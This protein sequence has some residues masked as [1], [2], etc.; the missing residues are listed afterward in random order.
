[1]SANIFSLEGKTALVT[2]A[3][4]GLGRHFAGVL[5]RAGARVVAAAR[6]TERLE[7]LAEEIRREGGEAIPCRLDVT[8]PESVRAAFDAAEAAFGPVDV[9]IN[10]AG[11]PSNTFF[12]K[13]TEQDWRQVMD[14]NLDGV[15][16]VAQEGA[17][18]MIA[19]GKPGS[20]VNVSSVLG[21][22]VLK[23]VAPYAAS[24]AAVIQLTKAMALELARD[25]IR[26]N[27]LAPGYVVTELNDEFLASEAGKKLL[28]RVPFGRAANLKEL[29]GPLLLLASDAGSYMTGSVL[30]V[31]G[32]SLLAM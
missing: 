26:V 22:G 25:R 13:L 19:V 4:S 21:L 27:A 1:M 11:V 31:D 12:T 9:L 10:N 18:R 5:A 29:E 14:V 15:F 20:I 2:G 28:G 3:S 7:A 23:A 6:R 30:V 24:K 16:R 17:R 32:G 8:D